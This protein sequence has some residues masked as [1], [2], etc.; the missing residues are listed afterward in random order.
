M[1]EGNVKD[2]FRLLFCMGE[3][4]AWVVSVAC[5]GGMTLQ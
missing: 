3:G 5:E 2:E 4:A 1:V